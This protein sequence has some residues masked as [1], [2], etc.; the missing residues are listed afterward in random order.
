MLKKK[1]S[2]H[3]LPIHPTVYKQVDQKPN[4]QNMLQRVKNLVYKMSTLDNS[5]AVAAI[6]HFQTDIP[7]NKTKV[8]GSV[9]CYKP[10]VFFCFFFV[11]DLERPASKLID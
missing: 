8:L 7:I 9:S 6:K 4:R 3:I 1:N 11:R 5:S 10:L 2:T